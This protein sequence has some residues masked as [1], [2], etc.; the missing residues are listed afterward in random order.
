MRR[1]LWFLGLAALVAVLVI[2]LTQAGGGD[3][4]EPGAGPSLAELKRAVADAPAPLAALYAQA[5]QIVP[6]SPEDFERRLRALRGYPVVVN[7][8][9]SWCGPCK[10]EFPIFQR[11]TQRLGERVAFLGINL[12]DGK[13]SARE[14]LDK[15]PVPYPSLEDGSGRIARKAAPGTQGAP[16]TI[17]YDASGRRTFI[18]QGGYE[19]EQDLIDDIERYAG[20]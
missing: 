5:N 17:Y 16:I 7:V 6:S 13:R 9:G 10:A 1:A 14:F 4:P 3:S 20:A 11:A 12:I 2:G 8:W 15:R 18:H 19:R